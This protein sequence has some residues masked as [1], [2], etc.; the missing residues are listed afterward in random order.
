MVDAE[1]CRERLLQ[2]KIEGQT[3]PFIDKNLQLQIPGIETRLETSHTYS[4]IYAHFS[5]TFPKTGYF[6]S[7]VNEEELTQAMTNAKHAYQAWKK[8][9]EQLLKTVQGYFSK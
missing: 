6:S 1:F 2:Y 3:R 5:Q 9:H 8:M 4:P 7:P